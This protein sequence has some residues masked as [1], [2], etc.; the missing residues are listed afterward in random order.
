MGISAKY[1][2]WIPGI[3]LAEEIKKVAPNIKIVVGGF[4]SEKE[5]LE[6]LGIDIE[7]GLEEGEL[8]ER[9]PEVYRRL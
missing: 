7:K 4:G 6:A 2:Q 3:I 5:A 8:F 1:S 9:I